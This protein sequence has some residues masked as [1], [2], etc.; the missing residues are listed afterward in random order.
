[1]SAEINKQIQ[2]ILRSL[3]KADNNILMVV[4]SDRT[5]LTIARVWQIFLG[6]DLEGQDFIGAI[7]TA[8]FTAAAEQ[9]SALQLGQ[10]GILVAEFQSGKVLTAQCGNG[11]LV[12]ITTDEATLGVV[13]MKML[14]TAAKL[15]SILEQYHPKRILPKKEESRSLVDALKELD[16]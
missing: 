9:G 3:L 1:M 8:V 14:D 16:F 7:A 10:L 13:R 11:I 15:V 12:V 5:G 6:K 4:L 2:S